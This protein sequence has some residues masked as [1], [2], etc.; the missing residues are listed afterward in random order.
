MQKTISIEGMACGHCS[1]RVE[2]ALRGVPGVREVA[3]DLAAKTAAVEADD[4]V[5]EAALSKAVTD[6]GYT[7]V[8]IG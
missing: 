2:K 8:G 1:A 6:S 4:C 3:V 5:A 7:V